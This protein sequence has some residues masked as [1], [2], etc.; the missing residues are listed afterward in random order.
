MDLL[1]ELTVLLNQLREGRVPYALC[2]GLAASVY[3]ITRPTD[4]IDILIPG[5][6]LPVL[7]RSVMAIG[8]EHEGRIETRAAGAI[9]LSQFFKLG[10]NGKGSV[11][12]DAVHVTPFLQPAWDGRKTLKTEMGE[13]CIVSRDG[14]AA[15]L[16]L[17]NSPADQAC[18]S[19]LE[20]WD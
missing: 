2:G 20:A 6:A 12:L 13:V 10:P 5:P 3:G 14:L 9:I 1:E 18:A 17:R 4:D 7:R 15:L 19:R 16:R 11:M 8:Y